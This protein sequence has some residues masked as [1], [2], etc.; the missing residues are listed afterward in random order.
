MA[1]SIALRILCINSLLIGRLRKGFHVLVRSAAAPKADR[2]HGK[3]TSCRESGHETD[4]SLRGL[5]VWSVNVGIVH[6][7]GSEVAA[8][9]A[10]RQ[11]ALLIHN[12]A[13]R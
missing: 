13:A 1:K 12:Q 8:I 7:V 11:L 6:L 2:H 4:A 5:G 10:R 9:E 3:T